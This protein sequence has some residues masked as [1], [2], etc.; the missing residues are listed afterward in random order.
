MSLKVR[1]VDHGD[2][3]DGG[4]G[5][6]AD[7][8]LFRFKRGFSPVYRFFDAVGIVCDAERYGDLCERTRRLRDGTSLEHSGEGYF[9]ANNAVWADITSTSRGAVRC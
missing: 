3:A 9:P 8:P 6:Q 7:T 4:G 2:R 5:G 1:R